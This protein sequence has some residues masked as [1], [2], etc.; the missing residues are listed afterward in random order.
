MARTH[1]FTYLLFEVVG[2]RQKKGKTWRFTFFR[3][4]SLVYF[5]VL[6]LGGKIIVYLIILKKKGGRG[7]STIFLLTMGRGVSQI[8]TFFSSLKG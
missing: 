7:V 3:L 2:L 1:V 6:N 4:F 8:L 5:S